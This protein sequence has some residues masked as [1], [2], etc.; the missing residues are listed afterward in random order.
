MGCSTEISLVL[1]PVSPK[2]WREPGFLEI[3]DT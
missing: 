2:T 1:I 3:I